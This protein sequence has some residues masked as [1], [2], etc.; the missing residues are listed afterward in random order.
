MPLLIRRISRAKWD[1]I[2]VDD[3]SA[4]AITSCLRT[5]QNDL[6]VWRISS[7]QELSDAILALISGSK[8]SKLSTLHYVIIDETLIIER[9]FTLKE[10]PGDTVALE[11]VD[12]HRDIE[13]LTYVKLGIIKDLILDCISNDRT[14]FITRKSLKELLIHAIKTGKI[15]KESLN[16]ELVEKENL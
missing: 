4:D 6:S 7:E 16:P 8:Q 9:G 12:K 14:S 2:G 13:N 3:V 5:N 11:L 15:K 1:K 10:T